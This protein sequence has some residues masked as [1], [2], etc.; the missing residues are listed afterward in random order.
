MLHFDLWWNGINL[1]R[2]SGTYSY[3]DPGDNWNH[4][5]IST[6]AHNT[7]EIGNA[8]QMIKGNR[9]RWYSLLDS[10]FHFHV[11]TDDFEIWQGEHNGYRRLPCKAI[12]RRAIVNIHNDIWIVIDDILGH[13]SELTRLIWN[14]PDVPYRDIKNGISLSTNNGEAELL[15]KA[16]NEEPRIKVL[17]GQDSPEKFGFRS[18]YYGEKKP[19]PVLVAESNRELPHRYITVISLGGKCPELELRHS[20]LLFQLGKKSGIINLG[21][22]GLDLSGSCIERIQIDDNI[23]WEKNK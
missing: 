3:Y 1:L 14:F 8:D 19:T 6:R 10:R 23:L 18:L 20:S 12:H 9:F 15:V 22:G 13:G 11:T 7:V 4:F 2:D 21:L 16:F 5:F 17:F